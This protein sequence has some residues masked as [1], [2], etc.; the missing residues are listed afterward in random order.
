M[1]VPSSDIDLVSPEA[2]RDPHAVFAE[3]RAEADVWWLER[4]KAWLVLGYEQV[5]DAMA[6]PNLSTDNIAPLQRRLSEADQARFQ[7]AADLLAGWMIFNDPPLHTALRA[8]VRAVFTPRAV[9]DLET[10]VIRLVDRLLDDVDP[11]GFD[12]VDAFAYPLPAIVIA[13]LL[14]VPVERHAEFKGWSRQLGALVMGKVSRPDAW[15]RALAAAT[16]FDALFSEM[17]A[18]ARREPSDSLVSRLAN[19]DSEDGAL[20]DG[21]IVGAC[22]L[23]LFGGHETTTSLLTSGTLHLLRH[24]SQ[25]AVVDDQPALAIEELLRYDGPSKM[26]VRRVR[27]DTDWHGVAFRAGQPVFCCTASANR[28]PR[29]FDRPSELRLDRDPNRHLG[30]GWSLH[31]CLGAQLARL[32]ARVALP[33]ILARFPDLRLSTDIDALEYQ[34]TIVGRTL[35]ALPLVAD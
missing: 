32:E 6:D 1:T 24:P 31:Y 34:P 23:L 25:R 33:R 14:G 10:D 28:D 7:P 20:T 11:S 30:F 4:H 17:L 5:K 13:I 35:R 8:P 3:L 18:A 22:S 26:V 27:H 16:D 15:E 9:A 2:V 21:Q 19:A 29:V 12:L